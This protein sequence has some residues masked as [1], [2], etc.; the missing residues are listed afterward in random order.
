VKGKTKSKPLWI[1]Q[2]AQ[3]AQKQ[4]PLRI[5]LSTCIWREFDAA[6]AVAITKL[7]QWHTIEQDVNIYW[8][9]GVGDSLISRS[10]SEQATKFLFSPHNSDVLVFI[11]SD[12]IFQPEQVVK[13][14]RWCQ[15]GYPIVC[16][17]Y[18]TRGSE[19]PR[20]AQR[21]TPGV[22][23]DIGTPIE[24][25]VEITYPSTGFIA[26]RRDVVQAVADTME[27]CHSGR[28]SE[29]YPLFMPMVYDHG[30]GAGPE[31][32]SE[33]WSFAR[34]AAQLGYK[35]YMDT[36]L[37]LGHVGTRSYWASDIRSNP[38]GTTYVL[39][40]EGAL[41]RTDLLGDLSQT[42]EMDKQELAE[43]VQTLTAVNDLKDEL[44]SVDTHDVD[45]LA[46][47]YN[48][49][50]SWL[51]ANAQMVF[52][53][54]YFDGAKLPMAASGRVLDIASP[55]ATI[56]VATAKLLRPTQ[57]YAWPEVNKVIAYSRMKRQGVP[58]AILD[59]LDQAQPVEFVH[60]VG[61]LDSM[62]ESM[63]EEVVRKAVGKL[64]PGGSFFYVPP[65]REMPRIT[66]EETIR[67]ILNK[68]LTDTNGL[69]WVKNAD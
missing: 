26:I 56:S 27:I 41:D 68:Y 33:D 15:Q 60:A 35:S 9:V 55:L 28:M 58:F 46:N 67:G 40:T 62:P 51:F 5:F 53:P 42:L 54:L 47:H 38:L 7:M 22:A 69:R 30:D 10:R 36:S 61:S 14:A 1:Q 6:T 34:R 48:S 50:K 4:Q 12:I 8:S 24:E 31:Y 49:S 13:L 57:Y 43:T 25:P 63:V 52:S 18:V 29:M 11:D 65:L 66:S 2:Q 21:L 16:G 39:V 59:N 45:A 37:I 3:Q 19:L 64:V 44:E 32:L 20:L 23:V 17:A